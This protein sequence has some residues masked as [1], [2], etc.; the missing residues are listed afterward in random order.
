MAG[1]EDIPGVVMVDGLPWTWETFPEF[2]DALDS[3]QRDIDV[4]A[5]LPH[6]PLRVYVM[7]QRGVDRELPTAEDLAMMRK[8]AEEAIRRGRAGLRVVASHLAQNR[9]RTTDSELRSGVRGDR[10]DRPRCRRRRRRPAAVRARSDGR[11]LRG[12]AERR[13]RRRFGSG[14]ARDVHARDRQR[15]PADPPRRT[16]HGREGQRQRRRRHGTDLPAADRAG[17]RPGPVRQPVRHV[18]GVPGDRRSAAGRAGG[19]DAQTRSAGTYSER[20]AGQRRA[21]ADV[22]R[23]GVGLHVPARRSAELRT[24]RPRIRSAHGPAPAASARS[25]RPTTGCS[26]TTV[27]R[28]CWSRWPTSATTRWT[29]WRS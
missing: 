8:L 20:Q 6:S 11:R 2:L 19:R 27:T 28:C 17:A 5:F 21:S 23:P 3:R 25:R 16:A 4:A 7:G 15:R 29:R 12:C 22:R 13:I 10:G 1:V 14:A 9:W 18:P 24:R 26:T